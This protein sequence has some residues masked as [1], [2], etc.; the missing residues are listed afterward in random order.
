[1][2]LRLSVSLFASKLILIVCVFKN[3]FNFWK[4]GRES[5]WGRI[6]L[7]KIYR[8]KC[9]LKRRNRRARV[10]FFLFFFRVYFLCLFFLLLIL[11]FLETHSQLC[12][13]NVIFMW[14]LALTKANLICL[15]QFL[16]SVHIVLS[17]SGVLWC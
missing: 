12:R 10:N 1:M 8:F 13:E 11:L 2:P 5:L 9:L 16:L 7:L 6:S 17:I 3:L 15:L 14:Q 4:V